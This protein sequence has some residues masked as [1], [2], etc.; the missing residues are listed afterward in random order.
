MCFYLFLRTC[1]TPVGGRPTFLALKWSHLS[2]P[3]AAADRAQKNWTWRVLLFSS[4][5]AP[6][7]SGP[8]PW[9][10]LFLMFQSPFLEPI[11]TCY[12]QILLLRGLRTFPVSL[13][14]VSIH[15]FPPRW[16]D[17]ITSTQQTGKFLIMPDHGLVLN[18]WEPG[19]KIKCW[20]F[21]STDLRGMYRWASQFLFN[22]W[23][24]WSHSNRFRLAV[25]VT[26]V[27]TS[28][29]HGHNCIPTGSNENSNER[30]LLHCLEVWLRVLGNSFVVL[31]PNF[32]NHEAQTD[33]KDTV[34]FYGQ[35]HAIYRIL[36]FEVDIFA[37]IAVCR[38]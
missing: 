9:D 34:S 30:F 14:S 26:K 8:V 20:G 28:I 12:Y 25:S 22:D 10:G 36:D 5:H 32:T 16:Q 33:T 35:T 2:H 29:L 4:L 7:Q 27:S 11:E 37:I 23:N 31:C 6:S 38:F 13:D 19:Q 18:S 1:F 17:W 21:I 15:G 3:A 24:S